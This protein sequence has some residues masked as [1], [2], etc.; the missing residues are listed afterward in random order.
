MVGRRTCDQEL[1]SSIP[2]RGEFTVMSLKMKCFLLINETILV[3][4]VEFIHSDKEDL[5]WTF[6]VSS[7]TFHV[8]EGNSIG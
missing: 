8:S 4:I 5:L 3:N 2:G 7:I 6:T 1:A